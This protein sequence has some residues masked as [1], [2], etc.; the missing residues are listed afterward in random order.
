MQRGGIRPHRHDKTDR[1]RCRYHRRGK[2]VLGGVFA[3]TSHVGYGVPRGNYGGA[4][5]T[6]SFGL[7]LGTNVLVGGSH[8]TI[9]LQPFSVEGQIGVNL[10]LGVA[11]LSGVTFPSAAIPSFEGEASLEELKSIIA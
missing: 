8:R 1:P 9:S 10:A 4:S 11:R 2:I 3:P 5:R 7:G 6:V